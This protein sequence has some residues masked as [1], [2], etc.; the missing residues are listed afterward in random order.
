MAGASPV[1]LSVAVANGGGM[2][3]MG[4]LMTSPSGIRE[5]VRE[6]RTASRGPFQLNTWVPDPAPPRDA[7][8]EARV[9]AFLARW[10]P[11]VEAADGD[12]VR[13]DFR[14]QCETFV[15]LAPAAVSSI[16]GLFPPD[17]VARFKAAG[18]A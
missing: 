12:T 18:I 16:M 5:W 10:G 6:H 17:L 7:N 11:D 4:A 2:G 9:R 8:A 15:E 14:A 3:A 13:P 1:S